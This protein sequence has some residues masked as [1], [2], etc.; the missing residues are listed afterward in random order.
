MYSIRL[1]KLFMV[2]LVR[3]NG[4]SRG[5]IQGNLNP[6]NYSGTGNPEPSLVKIITVT[7]KVQRLE[8]E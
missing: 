1:Q 3:N 4:M 2:P 5:L 7:R 6:A 8:G